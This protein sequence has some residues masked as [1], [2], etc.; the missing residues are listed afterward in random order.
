MKKKLWA[1]VPLLIIILSVLIGTA[2]LLLTRPV[3]SQTQTSQRFVIPRGQA[4]K[5]IAN[6]LQEAGLIK[7]SLVFQL[8]IKQEGLDSDIQAGSFDLS[9]NMS[10]R[11]IAQQLTEGT[12]DLWVT[13]LE[14][15][16]REEIA[17]SLADQE[18]SEFSAVDFLSLTRGKEGRLFPD[19]YLVSREATAEQL[20]SLLEQTFERK[21]EQGLEKEIAASDYDFEEALIMAS[22]VEREARGEAELRTVAGILWNRIEIGMALQADATLQYVKGYNAAEDAWWSPPTS[23]DKKL[24]SVYNTYLYPGLPPQPIANP[25]LA[26]I[27]A[28]LNPARTN[29]FYYLHD[30]TGQA[31]YAVNLDEHNANINAYLR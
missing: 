29:Y 21:V 9:P 31:H 24:A 22:I 28:A 10:A 13:V 11:E 15:W 4:I 2:I 7:N 16:R 30:R 12:N 18:L 20:A 27:K 5:I 8:I 23:A 25:G 19:T 14:G 26:A 1:I 3:D 6:R 17:E